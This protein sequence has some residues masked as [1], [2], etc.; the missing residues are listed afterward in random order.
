MSYI[1]EGLLT[2]QSCVSAVAASGNDHWAFRDVLG[3]TDQVFP[4]LKMPPLPNLA[5]VC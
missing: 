3:R 5:H 1:I 4:N 2:E